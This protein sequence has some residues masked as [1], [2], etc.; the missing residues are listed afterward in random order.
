MMISIS[1]ISSRSTESG[2]Y[3]VRSQAA[4]ETFARLDE[5]VWP[6]VYRVGRLIPTVIGDLGY[7]LVATY[8]YNVFGKSDVCRVPGPDDEQRFIT[9]IDQAQF[10]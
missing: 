7:R 1:L 6:F 8:R 3:Y 9:S 5:P 2:V 4:L 10:K